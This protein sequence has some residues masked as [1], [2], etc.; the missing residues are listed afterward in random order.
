MVRIANNADAFTLLWLNN[1]KAVFV[2]RG[3]DF[4]YVTR[5]FV[6]PNRIVKKIL[7]EIMASNVINF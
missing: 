7:A 6:D 2:E 3:F 5:A 4:A 1:F